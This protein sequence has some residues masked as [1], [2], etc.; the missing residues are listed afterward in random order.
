LAKIGKILKIRQESTNKMQQSAFVQKTGK[1]FFTMVISSVLLAFAFSTVE[2]LYEKKRLSADFEN[3]II[4]VSRRIASTLAA[5]LWFV[6]KDQATDIIEL[7]MDNRKIHAIRV[8]EKDGKTVFAARKRDEKGNIIT[9]EDDNFGEKYIL[10]TRVIYHDDMDIG[11]ADIFF[12]AQEMNASLRNLIRYMAVKACVMSLLL[13]ALLLLIVRLT[14]LNKI[15]DVIQGLNS[16]GQKIESASHRVSSTGQHLTEG[17]S[18]QAAAVE[19]T[20]ASLEEISS[21]IQQNARNIRHAD[22]LMTETSRVVSRA[23]ASMT[24]LTGT[25]DKIS[26]ESDK[27]QKIIKTIEEIAFQTNLLAL[28]AAVEAARAGESGSGFAV[29]AEEVRNL[30]MRSGDAAKNT[31]AMIETS[32]TGIRS[33]NREAGQTG[34]DFSQVSESARKVAGLLSEVAA[35]SQDQAESIRQVSRAMTDIDRVTQENAA[36]VQE[37]ASAITEIETQIQNMNH[38]AAK[39]MMLS[40][41]RKTG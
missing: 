25:M 29:V 33:G 19:Q 20:S 7:E 11:Y 6:N 22:Q 24:A 37:T 16:V 28:N 12:S 27:T 10:K 3:S 13:S 5:S 9:A 30:A 35:A 34:K 17:T 31:A 36:G 39:L 14:L 8:R 15:R 18:R 40:G 26:S 21:M 23:A 1:I 38:F 4:P 41:G 2:F 32:V